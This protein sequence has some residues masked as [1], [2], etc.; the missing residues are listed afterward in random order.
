MLYT[1][2]HYIASD[3]P[4]NDYEEVRKYIKKFDMPSLNTYR[5]N[6]VPY[7]RIKWTK[8]R[9]VRCDNV[10]VVKK[11]EFMDRIK[12]G[13]NNLDTFK[14]DLRQFTLGNRFRSITGSMIRV[15]G[16]PKQPAVM[17]ICNHYIEKCYAVCN[18]TQKKHRGDTVHFLINDENRGGKCW[19][20]RNGEILREVEVTKELLDTI[21]KTT[22]YQPHRII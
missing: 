10:L 16:Y 11:W 13:T 3:N 9:I 5:H 8:R 1:D 18:I 22:K 21:K 19:V 12:N 6:G 14:L 20:E 15:A 17:I 4:T 7:F 2:Y